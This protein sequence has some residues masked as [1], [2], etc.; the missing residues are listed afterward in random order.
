MNS[1]TKTFSMPLGLKEGTYHVA[2][3]KD[4]KIL[5]SKI[6]IKPYIIC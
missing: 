2:I 3:L 6:V 5:N 4:G 1:K